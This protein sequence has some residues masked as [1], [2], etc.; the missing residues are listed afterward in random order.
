MRR[1]SRRCDAS[2]D[3]RAAGGQRDSGVFR[4]HRHTAH[5]APRQRSAGQTTSQPRSRPGAHDHGNSS[6]VETLLAGRERPREITTGS[7]PSAK[8]RFDRRRRFGEPPLSGKGAPALGTARQFTS[9]RCCA[10]AFVMTLAERPRVEHT[11]LVCVAHP[12]AHSFESSPGT[13]KP[14]ACDLG[15]CVEL[16]GIEPLTS[17]M[18]W[19][20]STN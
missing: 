7:A 10:T 2:A 9:A 18:P 3:N 12:V 14:Q 17:S 8:S 1:C 16:R 11:T 4:E 20:R 19:K 13:T 5:G 6:A 15:F